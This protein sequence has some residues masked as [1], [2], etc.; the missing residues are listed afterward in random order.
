[1]KWLIMIELR[2]NKLVAIAYGPSSD[3]AL[4]YSFP[5]TI[6]IKLFGIKKYNKII[7]LI[8]KIAKIIDNPVM[9][10]RF[11]SVTEYLAKGIIIPDRPIPKK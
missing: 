2:A 1:M 5:K 8:I 11:S 6:S 7:G 4:T 10:N 9:F 3:E